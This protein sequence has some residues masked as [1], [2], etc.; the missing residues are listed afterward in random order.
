MSAIFNM[1]ADMYLLHQCVDSETLFL[2]TYTWNRP[3]I[4]I[5]KIQDPQAVLDMSNIQRDGAEWI[6][7]PT[8][9]RPVLHYQDCTYSCVFSHKLRSLGGSVKETYAIFSN[10]LKCALKKIGID[11]SIHDS[12]NLFNEL[13]R[14]QKLPCFLAPNRDEIMVDGKKFIGSAQRRTR[15]GVL[16][17]GSIPISDA[18]LRLPLYLNIDESEWDRQIDLLR[19]KT[20]HLSAINPAITC[21]QV[22]FAITEG[23]SESLDCSIDLLPWSS[24]EL[25]TIQEIMANYNNGVY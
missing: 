1:A 2:R 12:D 18:Y 22:A 13:K 23:F 3:S 4:T 19:N 14:Q 5:G 11:S 15:E 17:H 16:Q 8:G 9:G 10:C 7:R 6:R 24:Y 21:M 20:I 25:A